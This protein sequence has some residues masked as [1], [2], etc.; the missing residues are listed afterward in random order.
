MKTITTFLIIILLSACSKDC[1]QCTRNWTYVTYRQAPGGK[2][3]F[4]YPAPTQDI[5]DACGDAEIEKA[6]KPQFT[7]TAHPPYRDG[8]IDATGTCHCD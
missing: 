1:K 2:Y 7:H 6:E 8:W 5:F 4:T 3:Q